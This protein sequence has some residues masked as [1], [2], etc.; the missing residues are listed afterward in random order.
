MATKISRILNI[1]LGILFIPFALFC[2]LLQMTGEIAIGA[3]NP[4][5]VVLIKIIC[6]IYLLIPLFYLIGVI[7]SI[8]LRKKGHAVWSIVVQ[9]IPLVLWILNSVLLEVFC[10]YIPSGL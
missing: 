4:V 8:V 5:F 10:A 9:C 2:F 7:L 3:T 1:V 6:L